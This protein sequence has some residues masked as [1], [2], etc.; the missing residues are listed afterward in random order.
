LIVGFF[1]T[2]AAGWVYGIKEQVQT[3]GVAPV[4]C[5]M[6]ANFGSV[7]LAC[8]IWF[9]VPPDQ[10]GV[11]GGFVA[12]ICFYLAVNVVTLYLLKRRMDADPDK[13]PCWSK[14]IWAVSFKNVFDLKA[15][16]E[17]TIRC[18]PALWCILIKQ[19]IPHVLI[20]LFVNLA[21]SET[22]HGAPMFSGYGGYPMRPYQALG[23][24]TFVFAAFL[25]LVGMVFPCFYDPLALPDNHPSLE[26]ITEDAAASKS[27]M[28]EDR[29]STNKD[30]DDGEE[31]SDDVVDIP[32]EKV[33]PGAGESAEKK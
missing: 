28:L 26:F 18:I 4:Y 27:A 15:R 31:G 13:W 7:A 1:E 2:F 11:W 3:L 16:I 6:L 19:F 25:F 32:A 9:G 12:L 17:P 20:I 14:I 22:S 23:I 5:Y 29:D 10:G 33:E 21:Q 24:L 8:G 30:G